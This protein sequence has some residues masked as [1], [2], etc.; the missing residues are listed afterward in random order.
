[1]QESAFADINMQDVEEEKKNGY[2]FKAEEERKRLKY[3]AIYNRFR[4]LH[5]DYEA[6]KLYFTRLKKV[7]NEDN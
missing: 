6:A 3:L 1:M 7:I 5:I 2:D 4:Y